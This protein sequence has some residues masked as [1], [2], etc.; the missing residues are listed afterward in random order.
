MI[1]SYDGQTRMN[2]T[3]G[4]ISLGNSLSGGNENL[5]RWMKDAKNR[6]I[7][8]S[9]NVFPGH[10]LLPNPNGTSFSLGLYFPSSSRNLSLENIVYYF[11]ESIICIVDN[12]GNVISP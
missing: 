5:N 8:V 6:K 1:M 7:S 2:P 10:I 9:A 4:S 3:S 11:S 12:V